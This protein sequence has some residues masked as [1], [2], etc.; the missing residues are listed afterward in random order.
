MIIVIIA[1]LILF[2]I[3]ATKRLD[4]AVLFLV[5][6]LPTYLVRF[7][8]GLIPT[9]LLEMMILIVFVVW[10]LF[11]GQP[12]KNFKN[13]KNKKL[14]KINYPYYIEIILM[15]FIAYAAIFT[16]HL[17]SSA[18]G[19]FKAYLFEP[20]LLFI[21]IVNIF[22]NKAD[23]QKIFWALSLSAF[24]VAALAIFQKVTGLLIANPFWADAATRRAVSFFGYPNAVGLY[25]GPIILIMIGLLLSLG[26]KKTWPKIFLGL[27]IIMSTLAV[28]FAQSVGTII[29]F[30][31]K[32]RE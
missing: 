4:L 18:L 11:I 24:F 22:K 26:A 15:L 2:G 6:A 13:F 7:S 30:I 20:I 9:T 8:I 21:V 12:W 1:F 27:T 28:I 25:L 19:I 23:Y 31:I 14:K 29:L 3:L 32:K 5:A 10:F 17:S 16:A